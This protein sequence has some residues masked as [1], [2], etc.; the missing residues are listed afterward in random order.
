MTVEWSR[1]DLGDQYVL[2]YRD[3]HFNSHNQHR[4]FK[5]RVDLQDRQMKDGDASLILKN[6]TTNDA[7]TYECRAKPETNR[8]KRANLSGDP[9][10]IIYLHVDPPGQPG[11]DTEDGGKEAGGKLLLKLL[12]VAAKVMELLE[13]VARGRQ[14]FRELLALVA[15]GSEL[16]MVVAKV[17]ELLEVVNR[18]W[19]LLWE[20][21]EVVFDLLELVF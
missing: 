10:S 2:L 4:S 9:I 21:V 3:G 6:V 5:N 11:G 8:R 14:L 19:E 1:L 15:R 20:L 17:M 7:G 16:L 18:A 13:V 12:T